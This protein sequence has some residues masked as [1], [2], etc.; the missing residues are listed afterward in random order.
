MSIDSNRY[1][2]HIRMLDQKIDELRPVLDGK[3]KEFLERVRLSKDRKHD[4]KEFE[5]ELAEI[6]RLQK[7]LYGMS[8]E[9]VK[10]SEQ[11]HEVVSESLQKIDGELGRLR[12]E[13]KK[14]GQP[15]DDRE[16][17]ENALK[18]KKQKYEQKQLQK[19]FPSDREWQYDRAEPKYCYCGT[20]S[21]GEMVECEAPFCERE[22][23]H[24]NC[25]D[26]KVLPEQ[27]FC[28]NCKSLQ[29]KHRTGSLKNYVL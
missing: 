5:Q 28:K 22:W 19:N 27:W 8:L 6:E 18:K 4:Q 20:P 25:I 29:D 23:F 3:Q 24:R 11:L 7:L 17:R 14:S 9:K 13:Q 12:T 16:E 1:L 26:D 21:H 10:V 2:R 15:E